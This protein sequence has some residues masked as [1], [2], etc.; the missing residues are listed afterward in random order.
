MRS[1]IL[2]SRFPVSPPSLKTCFFPCKTPASGLLSFK[3]PKNLITSLKWSPTLAISFT[4][5]S[6]QKIPCSPRAYGKHKLE[7]LRYKLSFTLNKKLLITCS[8][9]L[10]SVRGTGLPSIIVYPFLKM[11]SLTLLPLG[12]LQEW[13]QTVVRAHQRIIREMECWT[14]EKWIFVTYP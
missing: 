12:Y 5:S 6:M 9:M 3:G 7:W 8:I 10:L 1:L 11:R 2:S 13:Q 14:I 4:M